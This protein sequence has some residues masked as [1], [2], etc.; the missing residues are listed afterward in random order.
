MTC[1]EKLRELHPDWDDE[2]IWYYTT[3][4]CVAKECIM[5]RPSYC[6]PY[7]WEKTSKADCEKCWS[8]EIPELVDNFRHETLLYLTGEDKRLLNK[9]T[10]YLECSPEEVVSQ[11]L[12]LLEIK[13]GLYVNH[14]IERLVEEV[15][16]NER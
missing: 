2:K 1:I 9:L 5:P 4:R 7:V 6:D 13:A 10:S 11:A 3:V 15:K 12:E 16:S 8:R 14:E